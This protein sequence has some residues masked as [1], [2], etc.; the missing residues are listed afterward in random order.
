MYASIL[1]DCLQ[2]AQFQY[3]LKLPDIFQAISAGNK[4]L[5]KSTSFL[6]KISQN[7]VDF[8]LGSIFSYLAH[9]FLVLISPT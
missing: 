6:S 2:A 7:R 1:I 8:T 3:P 5:N 9:V 4:I